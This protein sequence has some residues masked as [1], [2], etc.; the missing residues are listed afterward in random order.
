M[1]H[2]PN[3]HTDA[4]SIVFF[5]R[6]D[7]VAAGDIFT[8]GRFPGIDLDR[9]GSIN[10]LINGLNHIIEITIPADKQEGGTYVIPG[11]GHLCDEADVVEYRDMATIVRD[12]VQDM[13]K[14]GMTLAQVKDAKPTLDYD[15]LYGQA[16]GATDRFVESVYKSLGAKK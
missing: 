15:P 3:A 11:H 16:N 9:G 14:K 12:R 10:G 7:V 13:I 6:S 4:D 1:L 8:P 2:Q 5:R